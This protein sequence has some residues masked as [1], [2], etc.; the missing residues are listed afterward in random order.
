[1]EHIE[2]LTHRELKHWKNSIINFDGTHG[3]R[4]NHEE[5]EEHAHQMGIDFTHYSPYE[6][7]M[8]ANMLYSDYG[9]V[10]SRYIPSH[11][12]KCYIHLAKAFL[13]DKDTAVKGWEKLA[14]YYDEIVID[15]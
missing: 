1:M 9:Q 10:L 11:D 6:L 15:D 13:E 7:C 3:G 8:T 2:R 14:K 5:V 12:I 4:F